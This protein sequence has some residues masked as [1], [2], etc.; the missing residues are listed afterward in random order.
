MLSVSRDSSLSPHLH[1]SISYITMPPICDN[2]CEEGVQSLADSGCSVC[3]WIKLVVHT[4]LVSS[5]TVRQQVLR[6]LKHCCFFLVNVGDGC[7][8]KHA[9]TLS[10]T[11]TPIQCTFKYRK[12]VGYKLKAYL[13]CLPQSWLQ[14]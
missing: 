5:L 14:A 1:E 10:H 12:S 3:C 13:V 4:T 7:Q 6:S 2:G 9:P 8:M 11:H